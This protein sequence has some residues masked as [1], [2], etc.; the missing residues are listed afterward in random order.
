MMMKMT[1]MKKKKMM[2]MMMMMMMTMYHLKTK[3]LLTLGS[4]S[5]QKLS[6][7]HDLWCPQL[8]LLT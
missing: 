7:G 5:R 3:T 6:V 2:M 8:A 1:M 4:W